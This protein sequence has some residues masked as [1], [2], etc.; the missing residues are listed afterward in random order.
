M[1]G[2][3]DEVATLDAE[4]LKWHDG[5]S[6]VVQGGIGVNMDARH[7]EVHGRHREAM[8]EASPQ[9]KLVQRWLA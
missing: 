3:K 1:H 4:V 8:L 6:G 5:V 9:T 7:R 2:W